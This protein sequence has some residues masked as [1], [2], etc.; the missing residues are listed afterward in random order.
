MAEL[1]L[2]GLQQVIQIHQV[3]APG[4]GDQPALQVLKLGTGLAHLGV[5]EIL[6]LVGVLKASLRV[7]GDVG[8]GHGIHQGGGAAWVLVIQGKAQ[9]VGLGH[10]DHLQT[11][12][13]GPLD[14]RLVGGLGVLRCDRHRL[15][16]RGGR[17]LPGQPGVELGGQLREEAAPARPAIA[18]GRGHL[19]PK[20]PGDPLRERGALEELNLI[21]LKILADGIGRIIVIAIGTGGRGS[22]L[23][24]GGGAVDGGLPDGQHQAQDEGQEHREDQQPLA[25]QQDAQIAP[26][27]QG[28]L[29]LHAPRPEGRHRQ[30][31]GARKGM[32]PVGGE[33]I[34]QV[35]IGGAVRHDAD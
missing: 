22:G 17:F 11:P 25:M 10:R 3:L 13:N 24:H 20:V 28:L 5:V 29:V 21:A 33:G 34:G 2:V 27:V 15:G 18:L 30:I 26:Q 6:G 31:R 7:H 9:Q 32:A 4:I 19:D 8:F 16:R 12:A 14:G 1:L 35:A 23:H